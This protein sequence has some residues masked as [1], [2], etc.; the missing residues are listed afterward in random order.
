VRFGKGEAGRT[1]HWDGPG[2]RLGPITRWAWTAWLV[3][4]WRSTGPDG[5]A[6]VWQDGRLVVDAHG[7]TTFASLP[8][9]NWKYGI[10]TAVAPSPRAYV[11]Y[12]DDVRV[13]T[14]PLVPGGGPLPPGGANVR[15]GAA[16]I[17]P[18]GDRLSALMCRLR[19]LTEP[20]L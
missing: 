1:W 19:R 9:A 3:R 18:A 7:R 17:R 13:G 10:Y 12:F 14:E 6:Q 11:R 2:S 15:A 20:R 16:T 8:M 4:Y 5:P